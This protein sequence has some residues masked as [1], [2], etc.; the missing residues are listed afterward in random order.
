MFQVP[1]SHKADVYLPL[2]LEC[3]MMFPINLIQKPSIAMMMF[4]L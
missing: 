2:K 4:Y 3:Y 1:P